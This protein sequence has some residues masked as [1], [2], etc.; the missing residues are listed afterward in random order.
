MKKEENRPNR[1]SKQGAPLGT[2][3][4]HFLYIC[5]T[6]FNDFINLDKRV[7]GKHVLVWIATNHDLDVL[8]YQS[9][10]APFMLVEFLLCVFVCTCVRGLV[11]T[12][13]AKL[14]AKKP[15]GL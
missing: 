8:C 2:L 5:P 14:D 11:S 15:G 4:F 6:F 12:A 7:N 10:G 1:R 13:L 3:T 9:M